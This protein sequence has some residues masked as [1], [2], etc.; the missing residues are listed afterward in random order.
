[1][2]SSLGVNSSNV[3]MLMSV[4]VEREGGVLRYSV[5]GLLCINMMHGVF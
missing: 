3:F 5:G 1:M 2:R 4:C